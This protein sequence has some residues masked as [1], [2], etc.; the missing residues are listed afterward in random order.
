MITANNEIIN[1]TGKTMAIIGAAAIVIALSLNHPFYALGVAFSAPIAW[2]LYRWQ[3]LAVS[4][5]RGL[6]KHK[7]TTKL[8][9]RSIIRLIVNLALLGLSILVGEVFLFGVLTGLLLQV[10]AHAGQAFYITFKKGGKA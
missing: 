3:I 9:T 4:N 8:L 5:L 2:L 1:A 10:M 7:A 6:S